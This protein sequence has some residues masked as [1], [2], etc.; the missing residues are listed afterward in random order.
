ML[1]EHSTV[2]TQPEQVEE[3]F[4]HIQNTSQLYGEL[5]LGSSR[6]FSGGFINFGY[7]PLELPTPLTEE[8][9]TTSQQALY[10][11]VFTALQ[12]NDGNNVLEVACGLGAGALLLHRSNASLSITGID[13]NPAQV[14]RAAVK[15]ADE[16]IT[17]LCATAES[18]PLPSASFQRVYSVEAAQHFP[19][20]DGFIAEAARV[21]V[22]GGRFVVATF[23][24]T[25]HDAT[26]VG[27]RIIPTVASGVDKLWHIDDVMAMLHAHSFT[28]VEVSRI[29]ERVWKGLTQWV[30]QVMGNQWTKNWKTL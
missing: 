7:W 20:M 13:A 2:P 8:M 11:L 15:A 6:L 9:R 22:P 10:E 24:A 30:E 25:S 23:F 4:E 5:N 17:F 26:E 21:S 27:S 3:T 19:D 14:R 16:P 12:Y 28:D 29:G 1:A 18:L